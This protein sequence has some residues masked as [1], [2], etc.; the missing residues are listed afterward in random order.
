MKIERLH[1]DNFGK[2]S[3]YTID[4]S[5]GFNL[6]FGNNEDGKTT[7]M[8]FIRLMFYGSGTSKTDL[9]SNLRRRYTPFSQEK[10]GGS[11]DF[12][13]NGNSYT[14]SKQFGKTQKSDKVVLIDNA[15][16]TPINLPAG[17]E[18]GETFF[19]L[20]AG[21]FEKSIYLGSLPPYAEDGT[22]DLEKRLTAA[23][24]TGDKGD[25][26]EQI[27]KRIT[28]AQTELRTPRKVGKT[29]KLRDEIIALDGELSAVK[30]LE[31]E[32]KER[33]EQVSRWTSELNTLKE[34]QKSLNE[35]LKK[36]RTAE[37]S[38]A[39]KTELCTRRESAILEEELKVFPKANL[40]T[41]RTL[42]KT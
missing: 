3:D 22:A 41:A 26:Y 31:A 2:F 29:D 25:G 18:I 7:I 11:I 37:Q 42:L 6:V 28:A 13:H 10:M 16:G 34:E 20:S 8:S 19:S 38:A 21:A 24:Y 12:T 1:I 4:F 17:A 27:A 15:L 30:A 5:Q 23:V 35:L 36:S 39:I 9:F 33:E 32:R 40:D 14:L